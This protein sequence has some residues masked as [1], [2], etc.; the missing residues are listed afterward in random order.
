MFDYLFDWKGPYHWRTNLRSLLPRPLC[1]LW[2]IDKGKDC[3]A[4]GGEHDWY[5]SDNVHSACYHCKV[6]REISF[7]RRATPAAQPPQAGFDQS[8]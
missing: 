5:N 8:S 3:E 4:A 6:R 1:W 2:L 7:I